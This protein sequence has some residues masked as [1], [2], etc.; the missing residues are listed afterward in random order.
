MSVADA[1]ST[2]GTSALSESQDVQQTRWNK[3]SKLSPDQ[4]VLVV[5]ISLL[6]AA[7]FALGVTVFYLMNN[8][9]ILTLTK[10]NEDLRRNL[11]ATASTKPLLATC[12]PPPEVKNETYLECEAGWELHGGNCYK[13]NSNKSSWNESRDS[14]KD[15]GGDLVKIDSREEQV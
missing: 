1:T 8:E 13:F 14:C 6:A 15:L 2:N 7:V 11:S 12:P 4:L 3:R 9:V 5:L 10:E